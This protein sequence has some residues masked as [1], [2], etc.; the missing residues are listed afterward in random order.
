MKRI[1]HVTLGN[2]E[3]KLG[4]INRYC[5]ELMNCQK[6]DGYQPLLLYPGTFFHSRH[7]QIFSRKENEFEINDALPV[8]ITYGISAPERY[9]VASDIERYAKW[10]EH[11]KPQIIHVHSFQGIHRE[12]FIAARNKQIPILYTTHDYF[13]FCV[14]GVLF[15][16]L[17]TVC[18]GRAPKKCA[19]CN[20]NMGLS[21]NIQRVIQSDLYNLWKNLGLVKKLKKNKTQDN[22]FNNE[23]MAEKESLKVDN[24]TVRCYE[25]LDK[26][27]LE[28]LSCVSLIHCNSQLTYNCY[29]KMYPN[30]NYVILPITHSELHNEVHQRVNNE[31]LNISYMGGKTKH[32]GYHIL[33][34]AFDKLEDE[35]DSWRLWLYGGEYAD[36]RSSA[37]YMY[38]GVFTEKEEK[39][40]W[41]HTDLL[42]VPSQWPE[43]F[44]FVV[45]EALVKGIP[46]LC[47]DLVGSQ[48][49]LKEIDSSLIFRHDDS[50]ELEIKIRQFLDPN[51]YSHM[52]QKILDAHIQSNMRLH[53]RK[54]IELYR[55][56]LKENDD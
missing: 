32:K 22:D 7:P 12:F 36:R 27:Y 54:I 20:R 17:G 55:G 41:A 10:L 24:D 39:E 44:G 19:L 2:P 3:Y 53:S 43:T 35:E 23:D 49:L 25:N 8:P 13:P 28:I 30:A 42:I 9:M 21:V 16:R 38:R 45:L 52:Q 5:K 14:K 1:L 40:V 6:A 4:G 47:S 15:D 50:V 56:L 48:D 11:I 18:D 29:R 31:V 33:M 46:V 51:Y 37:S 26:Y 34:D